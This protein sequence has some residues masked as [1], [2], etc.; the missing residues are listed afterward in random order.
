MSKLLELEAEKISGFRVVGE[1]VDF[2]LQESLRFSEGSRR[3]EN[4][5]CNSFIQE[6]RKKGRIQ[7]TTGR[8]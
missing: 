4:V 7:E 8:E 6:G 2:H 1:S 5:K 3:L